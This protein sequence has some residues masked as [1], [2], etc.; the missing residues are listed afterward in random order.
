MEV[1]PLALLGIR[2]ALKEDISS[3]AA[4]MVYGATLRLPGEL[5]T[6]TS[7]PSLPDPADYVSRLRTHMRRIRPLPPRPVRRDSHVSGALATTTHVFIRRD[8]VRRPLQPPYD[9]PYSVLQRT[10]KHFTVDINGRKDTV[11][12]NRLKPAYLDSDTPNPAPNLESTAI[13][14]YV[15]TR[16][17]RRVQFPKYF[18][19][20]TS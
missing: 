6:P 18:T 20:Y 16:S 3:T 4:E 14:P 11:S 5:F 15:T 9:G 10:D 2:T 19:S 8:A 7:S 13:A 12:I 17:G 1:L